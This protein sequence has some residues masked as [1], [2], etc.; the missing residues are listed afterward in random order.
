MTYQSDPQ[1]PD[2]PPVITCACCGKTIS[3]A[4]KEVF[5]DGFSYVCHEHQ[6]NRSRHAK[7]GGSLC[8]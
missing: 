1:D 4:E 6:G 3:F 5:T 8:G 2:T 7:G